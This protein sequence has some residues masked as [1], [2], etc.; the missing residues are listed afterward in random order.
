MSQAPA[1][2][3][4]L[5]P[6]RSRTIDLALALAMLDK[7]VKAHEKAQRARVAQFMRSSFAAVDGHVHAK[8]LGA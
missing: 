2:V 4:P 7:G 3:I 6:A 5:R 1:I 8:S